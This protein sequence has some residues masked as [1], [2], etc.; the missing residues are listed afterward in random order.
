MNWR[1]TEFRVA[2]AVFAFSLILYLL[3]VAPTASFWDAGEFIA[4]ANQ[5]QVSHPPGAP[6]YM[7][8]G[9]AFSMFVPTPYIALAVNLVSVLA[10]ALTILLTHLIIVRLVKE[11]R[12]DTGPGEEGRVVALSA[13]VIGACTF[14]VTDSF[15]FN[16]VEAEVY[17]LSMLFTAIVVWLVLKWREDTQIEEAAGGGSGHLFGLASNRYLLLIAYMF[18]L[19]IGI[20]LLNLLAIFFI[21]LIVFFTEFEK[22]DWTIG[23]RIG[24]ILLAGVVASAFFLLV[25]PII[26]QKLP[27]I[28][29]SAGNPF[30]VFAAVIIGVAV[31]T[32]LTH[33]NQMPAANLLFLCLAMVLIGYSSYALIFIRSAANPPIDE[34]DPETAEAIVSYLKREQYGSTPLLR[35]FTYDNRL[36]T[37]NTNEEKLFPRRHSQEPAHIALYRTFDSDSQ[38]FW[39]Y[40]VGHMYLRYF[41]FNFIGRASDV[42]DAPVITGLFSGEGDEY[43]FS[44]PSEFA[45]RNVYFALPFLL[46][47]LGMLFHFRRDWRSA[48]SVAVLFLITGIGIIVYLNQTPFQPRERDYSYVASFFAFSLW[49]GIGAA[50]LLELAFGSRG[51]DS[52]PNLKMGVGV[53]I[54]LFAAVPGWMTLQNYDDHDRSGRYIAPDYAYNMLNSVAEDAI[55][56]TNGDN[57][58]FPLWYM[59]EVEGVRRDVRVAN[60]SL[61]N[62]P[63]YAK[64]LKY[65]YSR[66]SEPLPISMEDDA[67]SRLSVARWEP[68]EIT[69]P[70]DKRIFASEIL[71]G[72]DT[73]IV[74]SPMRW[75]YNGR[76]YPYDE[77]INI[78]HGAD[79]VALDIVVTAAR[80]GWQRPVYFAVTVSPDGE[81]DLQ[82][83]F[84][85]EGQAFR[86][87]PIRHEDTQL[88]RV[89]PSVTPERLENFRFRGL[90]DP[91]VYYDHNI[92]RMT[93]NYRNIYSH[94]AS[95]LARAG[96]KDRALALLDKLYEAMPFETIPGDERSVLLT[97]RSYVEAGNPTKA[98]EVMKKIEPLL[99]HKLE[100]ARSPQQVQ[101]IT[102]FI[103]FTQGMYVEVDAYDE[104][105]R[106]SGDLA[107]VAGDSALRRTADEYRIM[108]QQLDAAEQQSA[109][110]N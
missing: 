36:R 27:D 12:S 37:I 58:T 41:G 54:L 83:Y 55:L 70:V 103:R 14:A 7:L 81:L 90:D 43:F 100:F 40:Q 29:G 42:Q 11:W 93:D 78:V 21:A 104:A 97:S 26:I 65:Q 19:A 56:F 33:K 38:Y 1:D 66:D 87:V 35:G 63:W 6:V 25:Y 31:A 20:H 8:I 30:V 2:A 105:A 24:G 59:Q 76:D 77:N 72:I 39:K 4:I 49:I 101:E 108:K 48:L 45:S 109:N 99:L 15:W 82:E 9:R 95:A 52:E 98:I 96:D 62:T 28:A 71:T 46:G 89:E 86:I 68:R 88:G 22:D 51:E 67:L 17:A 5:L 92:R 16:A 61:L 57:D 94:T 10:S 32:Y 69:L 44:T 64:Q 60:L 34:N 73:S 50:G 3:T 13:G 107:R 85:L 84:Q 80:E 47:F 74:E 91:D 79:Q 102:Q 75:T 106:F 53:A 110:E 18:G 23:K